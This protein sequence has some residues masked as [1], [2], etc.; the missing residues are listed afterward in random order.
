MNCSEGQLWR[1]RKLSEIYCDL[2]VDQIQFVG[3]SEFLD[4]LWKNHGD[5]VDSFMLKT[6]D[7][8]TQYF[9][10]DETNEFIKSHK[11]SSVF[12]EDIFRRIGR[13]RKHSPAFLM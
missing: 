12:F 4:W 2:Y 11:W 8:S 13:V 9:T 6:R 1:V 5:K 7:L 10:S 3:D